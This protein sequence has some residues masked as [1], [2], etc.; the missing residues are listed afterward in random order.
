MTST[1]HSLG[2][3]LAQVFATG[4]PLAIKELYTYNAPG[5]GGIIAYA[6]VVLLRVV[7]IVWKIHSCIS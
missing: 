2:G 4:Y 3:H 5:L 6:V 1:G 7:R